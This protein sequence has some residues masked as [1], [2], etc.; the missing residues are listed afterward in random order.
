METPERDLRQFI[1]VLLLVVDAG[2]QNIS[3]ALRYKLGTLKARQRPILVGDLDQYDLQELG[4]IETSYL[5]W[6][7]SHPLAKASQTLETEGTVALDN[8]A[9]AGPFTV[10]TEAPSAQLLADIAKLLNPER[11]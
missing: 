3:G 9:P 10:E 1:E 2:R 11:T 8:S 4:K 7:P 6:F 5:H